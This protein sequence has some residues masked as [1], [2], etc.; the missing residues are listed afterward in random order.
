[1]KNVFAYRD[2]KPDGALFCDRSPEGN[3]A[4]KKKASDEEEQFF[5]RQASLPK[6]LAVV[7]LILFCVGCVLFCVGLEMLTGEE[8][9]APDEVSVTLTAAGGGL[10]AIALIVLLLGHFR[11]KRVM[12][13][14]SYSFSRQERNKLI[15]E[16]RE[17][18]SIPSDTVKTDVFA[19]RFVKGKRK[20]KRTPFSKNSYFATETDVWREGESF[21]V[22]DGDDVYKFPYETVIDVER[23]EKRLLFYGWNKPEKINRGRYKPYKI[24]YNSQGGYYYVKPCYRVRLLR[25]GEEYEIIFPPYEGET[26]ARVTGRTLP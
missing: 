22:F 1:M 12:G 4:A 21:C 6:V 20:E 5:Q 16:L 25:E 19:C 2:G 7:M 15:G 10:A 23:I 3:L 24:R 17:A 8:V 11:Q 26:L 14:R 18:L 9:S 13:S